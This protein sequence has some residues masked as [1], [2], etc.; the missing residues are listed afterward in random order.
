MTSTEM[1]HAAGALSRAAA[2][3]AEAK[4]DLDGVGAR[5]DAQL[6]GHRGQWLGGGAEAFFG[7]QDAWSAKQRRI[8]AALDGF[9]SRLR[10]TEADQDT[11]DEA[12]HAAFAR[13]AA[14]LG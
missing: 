3:T 8:V 10:S 13:Y 1:G 9:E 14:R 2:M 5:L 4:A 7:L 6:Q 12:Q 11:T